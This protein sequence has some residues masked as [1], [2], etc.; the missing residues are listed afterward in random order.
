MPT[1]SKGPLKNKKPPTADIVNIFMN[2]LVYR[3]LFRI[4][5]GCEKL[6]SVIIRLEGGVDFGDFFFAVNVVVIHVPEVNFAVFKAVFDGEPLFDEGNSFFF[7]SIF[8]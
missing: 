8:D 7:C 4:I 5:V 2:L 6:F 1:L 3:K